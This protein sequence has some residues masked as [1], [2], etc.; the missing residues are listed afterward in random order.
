MS[1]I[2]EIFEESQRTL[3]DLQTRIGNESKKLKELEA[4]SGILKKYLS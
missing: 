1:N 4:P 2:Q 3:E